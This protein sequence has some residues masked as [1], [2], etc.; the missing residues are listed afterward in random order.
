MSPIF[1]FVIYHGSKKW[2]SARSIAELFADFDLYLEHGIK[3]DFLIEP[4]HESTEELKRDGLVFC[5]ELVLA[6]QPTG[7]MKPIIQEVLDL[8]RNAK[9][10]CTQET[11]TYLADYNKERQEEILKEIIK[12]ALAEG[13]KFRIMFERAKKEGNT[14]WTENLK[15][16]QS[17][18][19]LDAKAVEF[20]IS[21]LNIK[22]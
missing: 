15:E 20:L 2:T 18:G 21:K 12:L 17:R 13:T 16:A 14:L 7:N 3:K 19:I 5:A 9:N 11:Y 22:S 6:K 1:T 4:A 10:C 8:L